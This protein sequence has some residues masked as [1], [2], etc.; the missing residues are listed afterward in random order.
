MYGVHVLRS[1]APLRPSQ[2]I[3]WCCPRR[4]G[5]L[6][7]SQ[8]P[9][10]PARA[11]ENAKIHQ[12]ALQCPVCDHYRAVIWVLV[13]QQEY[14]ENCAHTHLYCLLQDSSALITNR[15]AVCRACQQ[16]RRDRFRCSR[17]RWCV[18]ECCN[19]CS[20]SKRWWC[21]CCGGVE[22]LQKRKTR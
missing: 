9:S 4:T 10:L 15:N 8:F 20:I 2:C 12:T 6:P 16:R 21:C 19:T 13:A 5:F 3:D 14:R 18:L 17:E 7:P 1:Y 11:V 22:R